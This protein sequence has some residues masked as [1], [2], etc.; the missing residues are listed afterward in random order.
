MEAYATEIYQMAVLDPLTGLHNR[1]SGQRRLREEMSRAGRHDRSLILLLFDLN[2]LKQ[3]ND[4]FGH[5]AGDQVIK[6]FSGRLQ[7]AIRGSDLA[8][9]LGGDEF[10]VLLPECSPDKVEHVLGRLSGMRV[11]LDG[12]TIHFTFSAGWSVYF[13][14]ELPEGL[15]ERA[16]AALYVN[17]RAGKMK[18]VN[19]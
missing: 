11:D 19:V 13:P 16:D 8:V 17:K 4:N 15:I 9:R 3:I 14:G 5:L 6:Y 18:S 12:R 1:R 10:L 2:E 7:K